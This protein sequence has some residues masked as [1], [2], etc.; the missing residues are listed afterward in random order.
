MRKEAEMA[1]MVPLECPTCKHKWEED[2]DQQKPTEIAYRIFGIDRP[3]SR[4]ETY[5][6]K[7]PRDG[8]R[9]VA[10]VEIQE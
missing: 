3:R 2:L 7:C 5:V 9:V 10:D 4:V 8:T 1:R 6:F